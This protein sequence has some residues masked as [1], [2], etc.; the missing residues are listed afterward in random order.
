MVGQSVV[1]ETWW[2]QADPKEIFAMIH[3]QVV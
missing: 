1:W 3:T 2:I